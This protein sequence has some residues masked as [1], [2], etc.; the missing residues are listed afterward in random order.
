M[1]D[2]DL[3]VV[4]DHL[5]IKRIHLVSFI[6]KKRRVRDCLVPGSPNSCRLHPR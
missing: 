2:V 1:Y 3:I 5:H 6:H 4:M